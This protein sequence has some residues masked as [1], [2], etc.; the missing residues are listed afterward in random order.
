VM[1]Q[2]LPRLEFLRVLLGNE[3]VLTP[4]EHLYHRFLAKEAILAAKEADRW[5]TEENFEN[6]LDEVTIPALRAASDDQK[7]GV[8]GREPI[9][10]INETIAEYIELVQESLEYQREQRSATSTPKSEPGHRSVTALVLAG[11]GSLDSAAAQLIAGVIRLDLG[12]VARCPSLGG[13]TGIAAA[14]KA[15]PDDPPNVVALVSVGTVTSVQ[16]DLLLRRALRTFPQSRI[17]VGYWDGGDLRLKREH[18]DERVRYTESVTSLIDLVDRAA[19]EL[20]NKEEVKPTAE[21][22]RRLEMV[23][24]A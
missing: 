13:L 6:Y 7:R 12:I 8:L 14:A 20:S 1:G 4:H 19:Y 2:H 5:V 3:P 16:L 18:E 15:E 23:A 24:G 9:N 21:V 22:G 10:E 17:V 11:R